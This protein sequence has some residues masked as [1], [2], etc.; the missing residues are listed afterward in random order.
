LRCTSG[1][2]RNLNGVFHNESR[3][4]RN[5][6]LMP[7][8]L[9]LMKNRSLRLFLTEMYYIATRNNDDYDST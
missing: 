6:T 9:S 4:T 7:E 2:N 1:D 5:K 3:E 8:S